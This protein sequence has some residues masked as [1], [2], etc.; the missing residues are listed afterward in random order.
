MT[1]PRIPHAGLVPWILASA[2]ALAGL[3]ASSPAHGTTLVR[4]SLDELATTNSTIFVG[5]VVDLHSYWNHDGTFILTDVVVETDAQLKGRR[6]KEALRTVTLPGGTVGD[7]TTLLVG[8]P[9]L[10]IGVSYVLFASEAEMPGAGAVTTIR[11]HAQ[12]VF[13]L[14][15]ATDG[16]VMAVSQAST[17]DL[18]ADRNQLKTAPGGAEGLAF[19]ALLDRVTDILATEEVDR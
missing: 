18:M 8:G 1:P 7:L 19:D 16:D 12:G 6:T 15:E 4:M 3:C 10:E 11:N 14:V 2:V 13:E 17:L 5:E 9:R